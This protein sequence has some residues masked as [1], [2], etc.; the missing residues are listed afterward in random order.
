M[1]GGK[2]KIIKTTLQRRKKIQALWSNCDSLSFDVFN[3]VYV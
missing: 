3:L 1:T 2:S